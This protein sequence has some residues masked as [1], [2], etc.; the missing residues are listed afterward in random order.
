MR[1]QGVVRH[2]AQWTLTLKQQHQARSCALIQKLHINRTL[3]PLTRPAYKQQLWETRSPR[4]YQPLR[5]LCSK[6]VELSAE[7]TPESKP[8]EDTKDVRPSPFQQCPISLLCFL[9][10]PD[11]GIITLR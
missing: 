10:L 3:Q 1:W 8:Q 6:K 2:S 7:K 4:Q 11:K 9:P 5:T